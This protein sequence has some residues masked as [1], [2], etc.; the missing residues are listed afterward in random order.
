[1]PDNDHQKRNATEMP[2]SAIILQGIAARAIRLIPALG[3]KIKNA[4]DVASFV[5]WQAE[6]LSGPVDLHWKREDLWTQIH[7]RTDPS[8]P[9]FVL[10]FGVA[11]GYATE[12]WLKLVTRRNVEWHGFD[13]FTG[14][15]RGWRGM[16]EGKFNADGQ[17]PAIDDPRL[18]W[19]VGDV[20]NTLSEVDLPAA[21]DA[22]WLVLFDLDI[23]EPTAEAWG[24]VSPFLQPGDLL[25]FDEAMDADERRVLDELV[26]P[27]GTYAPIG[28]TTLALGLEV[29]VAPG[30]PS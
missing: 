13:R 18:T 12:H 23:Y 5:Q 1:M 10:E 11:W 29:T 17:V 21:R 9:L 7:G 4:G 20:E 25:Y 15:P 30:A 14:L 19:H 26:L 2:T 16:P 27:A 24:V 6:N 22:Q 3:E 28:A 8:M